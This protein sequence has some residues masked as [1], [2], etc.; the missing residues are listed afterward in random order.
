MS[1]E[2]TEQTDAPPEPTPGEW[3]RAQRRG[4]NMDREARDTVR[5]WQEWIDS[6][7]TAG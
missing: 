5:R 2:Q 7:D 1:S 6:Q 4:A 3:A